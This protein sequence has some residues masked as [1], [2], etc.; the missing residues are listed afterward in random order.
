MDF[1]IAA[2]GRPV[3]F[4]ANATMSFFPVRD[5]APFGHIARVIEPA[6][7]AVAELLGGE[8]TPGLGPA[9]DV[10]TER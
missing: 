2:N 10:A 9:G 7:R 1:A 3:L 4:E 8:V 5:E 6:R